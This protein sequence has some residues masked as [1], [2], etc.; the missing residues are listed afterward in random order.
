[1]ECD[2]FNGIPATEGDEQLCAREVQGHICAGGEAEVT[3]LSHSVQQDETGEDLA[4]MEEPHLCEISVETE[5]MIPGLSHVTEDLI[6]PEEDLPGWRRGRGVQA[7]QIRTVAELLSAQNYMERWPLMPQAEIWA[8]SVEHPHA[9][10][11]A[12]QPIRVLLDTKTLPQA[13]TN[14]AGLCADGSLVADPATGRH[15]LIP[16]CAECASDLASPNPVLPVYALA[17]DNL[18]LREPSAFRVHGWRLSPMTFTLLALARMVVKKIVAEPSRRADPGTKQK[19]LRSNTIAFPQA[20]CLELITEALPAEPDAAREFLANTISIALT[21][22]N[23]EDLE[24]AQWAQVPADAY[25]TAARFCVAHSKVYEKLV[26]DEEAARE[27]FQN[28]VPEEVRCQ[29]TR[30]EVA[31]GGAL[32]AAGPAE[33]DGKVVTV[34]ECILSEDGAP[35]P[36]EM[37]AMQARQQDLCSP[38]S[39]QTSEETP[40]ED[41]PG[42]QFAADLQSSADLDV[43]R[44]HQ[45]F[46]AKLELL[47]RYFE[48][49]G[50]QVDVEEEI[51]SLQDLAEKI[52]TEKYQRDVEQLLREMEGV[53]APIAKST[54]GAFVVGTA[55]KP[56]SMYSE[57]IWQKSFVHLFPYGDGVFGIRR[58][59]TMSFLQWAQMLLLRTELDYQVPAVSGRTEGAGLSQCPLVS[60]GTS[61][62][63]CQQCSTARE[64][65]VPPAQ[66]RWT[67]DLDLLCC[68]YDVWRRMELVRRANAYVRRKGFQADVALLRQ[69][70]ADVLG[71][72]FLELGP[73]AGVREALRAPGSPL[74]LK[75]ALSNLLLFSGEVVGTDGAR[76][77]LRHEQMGGILR[78]GGLGAFVTANVA[79]TRHPIMVVLHAG[80]HNGGA[81]GLNDEGGRETY[82]VDLLSESPTMPTAVEM[83]RIVAKN[84]VAQARFFIISMRLFCEHILGIGPIDEYLRH[85]GR[86]NGCCWPDGY[87]ASAVGGA[88]TWWPPS[89]GPLKSRRDEAITRTWFC[90]S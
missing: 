6:A 44:A 60:T 1:M 16:C 25:L 68:M 82:T 13:G 32:R 41:P 67:A 22:A 43:P 7:D 84:P 37:S 27:R 73:R 51:V 72:A 54:D 81:G 33:L 89:M 9:R 62:T 20:T 59:R 78:F 31:P 56:L 3:G 66:P 4:F 88:S 21:G 2:L 63:P 48:G 53:Q 65:F 5:E 83:L 75:T 10:N 64:H 74:V 17:N 87:A 39:G 71:K 34:C 57:E 8:T 23:V 28:L 19:G 80:Q 61:Q 40:E 35:L 50:T 36:E 52:G 85:N 69:T 58:R 42:I 90:S 29:A 55:R 46:I 12:E 24:N 79:D 45:E 11:G 15:I 14:K 49:Q 47:R 70:T 26:I 77:Q 38:N 76:Q 18:I 30:I 86:Q